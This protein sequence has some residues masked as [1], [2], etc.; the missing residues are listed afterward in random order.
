MI[1]FHLGYLEWGA[2]NHNFIFQAE[3]EILKQ[4]GNGLQNILHPFILI[5][6][7][8]LILLAIS[9]FQ[10]TPGKII[11]LAGLACL[12]LLML[13]LLIVGLLALNMKILLSVIPFLIIAILTLRQYRTRK[14][15]AAS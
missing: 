3:G 13:F 9:L 2:G 6:L 7:A 14:W 5:P 15:K 8:G 11:T 1:S 12:S 4:A 10:K